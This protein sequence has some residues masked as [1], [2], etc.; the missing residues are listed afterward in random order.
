[1]TQLAAPPIVFILVV[2]AFALGCA[3]SAEAFG[4]RA[5]YSPAFR[6]YVLGP[7][8]G[9]HDPPAGETAILLRDPLTGDKLV[10]AEQIHAVREIF[11]DVATERLHDD[12]VA[13]GVGVGVGVAMGPIAA[14]QPLGA[15]SLMLAMLGAETLYDGLASDDAEELLERAIA[16]SER[17]RHAQ[18][19]RLFVHALARDPI[20][21]IVDKAYL[22]LGKSLLAQGKRDDARLALSLFVVRAG[23]RDA[24]AYDEAESLLAELGVELEPCNSRDPVPLHW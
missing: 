22:H 1:M 11:E 19:E 24:E 21:G 13:I 2:A 14:L 10:C 15:T 20:I 8:D 18:A 5:R 17:E 3:T 7:Y 4:E 9:S 16:L 23:V 12:R 6:G